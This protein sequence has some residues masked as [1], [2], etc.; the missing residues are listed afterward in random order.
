MMKPP[1]TSIRSTEHTPLPS[2]T[3]PGGEPVEMETAASAKARVETA[4]EPSSAQVTQSAAP[5]L[6]TPQ[7][8]PQAQREASP[9]AALDVAALESEIAR[10]VGSDPALV[11]VVCA[12]VWPHVLGHVGGMIDQRV[13]EGIARLSPPI[14][15]REMPAGLKLAHDGPLTL[16][17]VATVIPRVRFTQ[18]RKHLEFP[19]VALPDG[20]ISLRLNHDPAMPNSGEVTIPDHGE[21]VIS[22]GYGVSIPPGW[23][24]DMTVEGVPGQRIHV[25]TLSGDTPPNVELRIP[26]RSNARR[27]FTG[28]QEIARLHL[29]RAVGAVVEWVDLHGTVTES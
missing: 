2:E 12:A 11:N 26:L 7:S 4:D 20:D 21:K 17:D 10:R 16:P 3:M 5:A 15:L 22:F 24:A 13:A 18:I 8:A 19:P 9:G 28:G 14:A 1:K 6:E 29:R 23:I 27:L 25:A